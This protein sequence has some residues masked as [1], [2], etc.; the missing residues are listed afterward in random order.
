[1]VE[2]K[3]A[4][5]I[6]R[7]ARP[8]KAGSARDAAVITVQGSLLRTA[9]EAADPSRLAATE[10]VEHVMFAQFGEGA[11]EGTTKALIVTTTKPR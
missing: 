2:G 9:I 10:A 5:R 7:I 1:L 6:D 8:A 3:V 4:V 11:V